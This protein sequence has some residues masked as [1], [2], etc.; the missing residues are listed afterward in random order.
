MT[1]IT[2]RTVEYPADGLTMIGHLALPVGDDRRPA[3]L[4]GPEGTGLSDVERRRADALAELGY[5]ALAFDLH[6]GRY[7][8]DPEE[9]LARC[10]P[11]LAD[12]DRMRDI[13][14][15]AL[16]VLLTEPR[17]DPDRIAA[18]GYGTG[19]AIG[20][21][22]GRDGVDL[23]A[24]AT[25]NGLITGRPGEAARIRCPVWAG[26][27]SEDPIMAPAQRDA[28]TVEMQAAG[29]DWRL[30][31]YGG[32]LHAFHHPSVDHTVRPGVGHHPRHAQR[33][34]RDV[35]ALL[36]ECLPVTD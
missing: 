25:V 13:G 36:A 31:V 32:A 3:V 2:T 17:A 34:W 5:V 10:M 22:L 20:L 24:I 19:G 9:M 35:V 4:L 6:G 11:M 28:F 26:V 30:M 27:G 33:A 29:V 15:A 1:T 21:E 16:D 18:V 12:P 8:D 7:L 23:R 14:H